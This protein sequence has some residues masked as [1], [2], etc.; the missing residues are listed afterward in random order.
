MTEST[1][2]VLL[3]LGLL[4]SSHVSGQLYVFA[5]FQGP[6]PYPYPLESFVRPFSQRLFGGFQSNFTWIFLRARGSAAIKMVDLDLLFKITEV[7]L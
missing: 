4:I 3:I 7:K 1:D 2:S 6:P 5:T